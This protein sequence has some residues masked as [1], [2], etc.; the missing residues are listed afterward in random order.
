MAQSVPATAILGSAYTGAAVGYRVLDTGGAEYSAFTTTGV[1][2]GPSGTFSALVSAPDA[3][4]WVVWGPSGTD[5]ARGPIA[6]AVDVSGIEA[7]LGAEAIDSIAQATDTLLS[8]NHGAGAWIGQT[9]GAGAVAH[10]VTVN[11]G[12]NPLDGAEVWVT[13]DEAGSNVVASGVT[14]A[15]GRVTLY[16][17]AGEYYL[18]AQLSGYNPPVGTYPVAFEVSE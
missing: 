9:T 3:G 18:W 7:T 12:A 1:V 4:G 14:D 11:D 17:D 13:T 6:P 5:V 10:T 15:L 16:L 8:A 2:E